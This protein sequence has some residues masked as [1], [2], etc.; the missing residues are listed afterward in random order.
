MNQMTRSDIEPLCAAAFGLPVARARAPDSRTLKSPWL[1]DTVLPG[2]A[3]LSMS[4]LTVTM[5][6]L[7]VTTIAHGGWLAPGTYVSVDPWVG[8]SPGPANLGRD[9][10]LYPDVVTGPLQ[11]DPSFASQTRP[12]D[13]GH[14]ASQ[15][16]E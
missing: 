14:F 2:L 9:D 1:L 10:I 6:V 4:A 5:I 11:S 12:A 16:S 13:A 8:V 15:R 7:V 3:L